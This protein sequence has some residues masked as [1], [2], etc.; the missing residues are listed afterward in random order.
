MADFFSGTEILIGTEKSIDEWGSFFTSRSVRNN[1]QLKKMKRSLDQT[2]FYT[3]FNN[4]EYQ[5]DRIF[6]GDL[7]IECRDYEFSQEEA[8]GFIEAIK[9]SMLFQNVDERVLF[10]SR[11]EEKLNGA[12]INKLF[13]QA[14]PIPYLI[15][16]QRCTSNN[17]GRLTKYRY[18]GFVS[19]NSPVI[20]LR[21]KERKPFVLLEKCSMINEITRM[22]IIELGRR[23]NAIV[24]ARLDQKK[25]RKGVLSLHGEECVISGDKHAVEAAHI[26]SGKDEFGNFS[27]NS[28]ENGIPLRSDIHRA[29]DE[30]AIRI[31]ADFSVSVSSKEKYRG[32]AN[33]NGRKIRITN[34]TTEKF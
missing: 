21:G 16:S 26:D 17:P 30:G 8:N 15:K 31:L 11:K 6:N 9:L 12:L 27:N 2:S 10:L 5:S 25:F 18:A 24:K 14:E 33:Y 7:S 29:F 22:D 19:F 4:R 13:E 32:L 28:P 3:I 34:I 1:Y 20:N 23:E